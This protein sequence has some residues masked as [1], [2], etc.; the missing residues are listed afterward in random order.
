MSVRIN[1]TRA[2]GKRI[3]TNWN[4]SDAQQRF[5]LNLDNAALTYVSG[6]LAKDA[7]A[8]LTLSRATLDAI[9]LQQQTVAAAAQ[10]GQLKIDGDSPKVT[11][12][13]NLLDDF[14]P[15]FE[16]VEPKRTKR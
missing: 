10:A 16:I 8:T 13:L 12:L 2:E 4:V 1:G 11:E 15:A 9:L 7:D 5:A 6:K 3:V 14:D